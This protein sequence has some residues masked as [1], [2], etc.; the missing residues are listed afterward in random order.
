MQT[1]ALSDRGRTARAS[2]SPAAAVGITSRKR[3]V[4]AASAAD[5]E[6]LTPDT[7]RSRTPAREKREGFADKE[8]HRNR[9]AS[10]QHGY[11][12]CS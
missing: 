10:L 11:D 3:I 9:S 5:L 4:A 8:K 1:L 2:L 6:F 12:I 7:L